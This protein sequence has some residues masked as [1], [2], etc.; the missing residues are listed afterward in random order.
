M[1]FL[2]RDDSASEIFKKNL[3]ACLQ[4]LL[5][6]CQ[7]WSVPKDINC[8]DWKTDVSVYI[9]III[10]II[11]IIRLPTLLSSAQHT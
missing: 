7:M 4:K 1:L 5:D 9:I 6:H 8:I 11:I 10:I 3:F 2:S